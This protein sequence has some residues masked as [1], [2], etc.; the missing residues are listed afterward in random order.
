[1]TQITTEDR[2]A[3]ATQA[4]RNRQLERRAKLTSCKHWVQAASAEFGRALA[5]PDDLSGIE[6]A[7]QTLASRLTD[8][9]AQARA[10]LE[11]DRLAGEIN[12]I[13]TTNN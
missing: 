6:T 1:M 12:E 10:T 13:L 3:Y 2:I 8:L 9:A 7:A 11:A 4:I 5:R